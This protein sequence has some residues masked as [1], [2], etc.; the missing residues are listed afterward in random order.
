M[1]FES[2]LQVGLSR[3]SKNLAKFT[4]T[5]DLHCV[6]NSF[7]INLQLVTFLQTNTTFTLNNV[8]VKFSIYMN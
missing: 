2:I 5:K 6:L 4:L 7:H 8:G 3:D 1:P